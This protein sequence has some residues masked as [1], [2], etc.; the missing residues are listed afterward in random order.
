M[1]L[2]VETRTNEKCISVENKDFT[3]PEIN[4]VYLNFAGSRF[5]RWCDINSNYWEIYC[6]ELWMQR[7]VMVNS[8]YNLTGLCYVLENNQI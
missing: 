8:T 4:A 1:N 2:K 3:L 7:V 5:N 6:E